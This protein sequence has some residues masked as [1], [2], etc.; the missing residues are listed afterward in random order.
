MPERIEGRNAVREALKA[1]RALEKLYVQKGVS[2][3]VIREI[4]A[5][6]ADQGIRPFLTEKEKQT[7]TYRLNMTVFQDFLAGIAAVFGKEE[8]S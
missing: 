1:G 4:T 7:I 6:A 8:Q 3:A 2:D 5:G